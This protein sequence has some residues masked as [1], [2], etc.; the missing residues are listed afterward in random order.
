MVGE[1]KTKVWVFD[2]LTNV[3]KL[4]FHFWKY[5]PLKKF[6]TPHTK[7]SN[8]PIKNDR[9]L[10]D[11][12]TIKDYKKQLNCL[13]NNKID[14]CYHFSKVIIFNLSQTHGE[15]PTGQWP[16]GWNVRPCY[17][18]HI[19]CNLSETTHWTVVADLPRVIDF[20]DSFQRKILYFLSQK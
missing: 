8:F 20:R 6:H 17:H 12:V 19:W 4:V 2:Y 14:Q 15:V 18:I 5:F 11:L 10:T 16:S 13:F 9:P 7:I 3:W 1:L